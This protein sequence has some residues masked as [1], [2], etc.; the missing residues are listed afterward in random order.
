MF[1][2]AAESSAP[3]EAAH[4]AA[5]AAREAREKA[6]AA[7][8]AAAKAGPT[9]QYL[10]FVPDGGTDPY[11]WVPKFVGDCGAL[12]QAELLAKYRA[13]SVPGK[14][15]CLYGWEEFLSTASAPLAGS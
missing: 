7:D 14:E 13:S 2:S 5:M 6:N 3:E 10:D 8:A 4:A 11:F 12:T 15:I 1:L 9:K